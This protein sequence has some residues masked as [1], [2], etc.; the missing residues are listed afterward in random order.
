VPISASH[1]TTVR[2]AHIAFTRQYPR[3]AC[4]QDLSASLRPTGRSCASGRVLNLSEGGMLVATSDVDVG[5][6][7]NFELVGPDFR[8]AGL[9]KVTHRTDRAT[10]LRFLR[11]QG[12]ADRPVRALIAARIR[13]QQAD[14]SATT[15]PGRYLG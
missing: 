15:I 4:A 8:F 6:T 2:G 7:T 9:A 5:R 3:I 14:S 13:Q 12:P 10:G 1:P 11:W